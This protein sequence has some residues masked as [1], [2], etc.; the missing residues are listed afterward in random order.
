MRPC[1]ILVQVCFAASKVGVDSQYSK[2]CIR[3]SSPVAKQLK[4]SDLSKLGSTN[5]I[6]KLV[7]DQLVGVQCPDIRLWSQQLKTPDIQNLCPFQICFA[8]FLYFVPLFSSRLVAY[9]YLEKN[10]HFDW[11]RESLQSFLM[12]YHLSVAVFMSSKKHKQPKVKIRYLKKPFK[13]IFTTSYCYFQS[14]QNFSSTSSIVASN[15]CTSRPSDDVRHIF[16]IK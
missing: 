5:N 10:L 13:L 6:T 11:L 3:F 8:L 15:G 9:Y 7:G 1:N 2:L 4:T 16:V 12:Q 14:K